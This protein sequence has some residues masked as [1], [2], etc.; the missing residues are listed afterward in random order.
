MQVGKLGEKEV[1]ERTGRYGET[2]SQA[3]DVVSWLDAVGGDRAA[4]R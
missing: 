1:S 4:P 3:Q 2:L